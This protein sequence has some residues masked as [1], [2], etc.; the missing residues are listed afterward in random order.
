MSY[1]LQQF[2]NRVK[3][4][5]VSVIGLGVSNAPLIKMLVASGAVVTARDRSEQALDG[6]RGGML[7]ALKMKTVL[8]DG[9]L[10]GMEQDDI[11]FRTPGLRY[12]HPQLEAAR[13]RG[14]LVTSEMEM[15]FELCPCPIFGVTGSD[16]KTTTTTLIY[17]MLTA[18]GFRCH[19]GGNIGRPLLPEIENIQSKDIAV[20]E[21]S[22]FQLHDMRHSPDVAV[23]TNLS[24]NHLD[25]HTDM[26]EYVDAKKNI[27]LHQNPNDRFVYNYDNEISRKM[28]AA[29]GRESA[30][31]FSISGASDRGVILRDGVIRYVDGDRDE[32]VLNVSDIRLPGRHNVENYMAAIGAVLDYV[33]AENIALVART[34]AGVEHRI[35]H[36]RTLRGVSY[37][38]DSIASSPTRAIAGLRSFGVPLI[39]IA[40][41]YDKHLDY[42]EFGRLVN[43]RVKKLVLIGQTSDKIF[44]AVV[45]ADNYDPD[46][47]D[48]VICSN[49]EQAVRAAAAEAKDGD[50]VILSPASASFDLFRNFAERGETFRRIVNEL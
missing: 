17:E 26:Q 1:A 31:P 25:Y 37:Y 43:E 11:I 41:G 18:Q 6:E 2:C 3:G 27:F 12:D 5:S 13:A 50:V 29:S 16:G 14:A 19:K 42:T 40:G 48:I 45:G 46:G 10:D 44:N 33:D 24:P 15:F 36:V 23:I 38:N 4:K 35:E 8:G 32:A 47:M 20:V 21:L 49:F 39:L 28:V 7:K 30:L 34:F 22:S 9:Y